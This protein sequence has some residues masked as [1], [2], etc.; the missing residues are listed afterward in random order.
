[1]LYEVIT[2]S[3]HGLDRTPFVGFGMNEIFLALFQIRMDD[4]VKQLRRK[5]TDLGPILKKI[6][7]FI[8]RWWQQFGEQPVTHTR[9]FILYKVIAQ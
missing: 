6:K 9:S 5:F 1:M 3:L 8:F 7:K 2:A 4:L